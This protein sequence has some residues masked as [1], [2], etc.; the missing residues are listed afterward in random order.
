MTGP[1][2]P[3]PR[4]AA[5]GHVADTAS[6]IGAAAVSG[7]NAAG[8][9]DTD[10]G[11]LGMSITRLLGQAVAAGGCDPRQDE[12]TGL[13]TLVNRLGVDP[14]QVCQ[15][16]YRAMRAASIESPDGNPTPSLDT[17][18]IGRAAFDVLAAWM[19][20]A[21]E[22]PTT[23]A[24][25]D[26]LTTLHTR[27]MLDTVILK[28]CQRAERFEHWLSLLLID[29]DH[30]SDLNR[31]RGYGVGDQV[32]ERMGVLIR[33]YFRQQDWV[34][35][36]SEDVV[37]V[38]LPETGPEDAATLANL[39][40]TMLEERLT[41][42]DERQRPVSVSVAVASARPLNGYP[43]DADRLID[44]ADAA[45]ARVKDGDRER[46]ELVEIH[47]VVEPVRDGSGDE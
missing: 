26:R 5:A 40:R 47:P 8:A 13:V 45:L 22:L 38:L 14:A 15:A 20:R 30:L 46:L 41:V 37:A 35:R 42:D 18:L 43:I 21:L 24:L 27:V 34:A 12:V 16:V 7:M 44:E 6:A 29:L 39:M 3:E 10:L 19:T 33:K 25:T 2:D 32:L 9:T 1:P 23:P 17:T 4:R 28:E 11:L 36:Y 31:T